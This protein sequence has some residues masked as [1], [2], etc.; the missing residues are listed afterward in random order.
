MTA[1]ECY[2]AMDQ[3]LMHDVEPSSYLEAISITPVFDE[4]PFSLLK[5]LKDTEQSPKHHPEGNVWNHTMLVVDEGA[6]VKGKSKDPRA[7]M[8]AALLHD[9][10]KPST[11][12][13]RKGRITAYHH[14]KEGEFIA[15][16]F[17][18]EFTEDDAFIDSVA[19][20]IRWHMQVLFVVNG[21][22]FADIQSMKE[23]TDLYEVALLGQCDRLGRLDV[24]RIEIE[25]EMEQFIKI[26]TRE[27]I[28]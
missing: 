28:D 17:L 22:P 23:Q 4:Y 9:I 21:L 5:K 15:R 2:F 26:C 14:E 1:R 20:L 12:K 25:K 13:V 7:F 3:H 10:G 27:V 18:K 16:G 8:W 24:D 11:T 6:K 19:Y